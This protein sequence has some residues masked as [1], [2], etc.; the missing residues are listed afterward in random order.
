MKKTKSLFI[1][2]IFCLLFF[3]CTTIR[4][5]NVNKEA[6]FSLSQYKTF[7]F[8][9]IDIDTV[10]FPEYKKRFISLEEELTKQFEAHGVK[11]AVSNPE[12]F[13]NIG[14]N[15]QNISETR[16]TDYLGDPQ[17]MYKRDYT[18]DNDDLVLDEFREGSFVIDFVDAK[19]KKLQCMISGD[20]IAVKNEK[21]VK[22][23]QEVGI[24]KIF[25]KI[26]ED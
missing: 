20:A 13:V 7:D 6:E 19:S 2:L 1:L 24:K 25:K 4:V 8:Y 9:Q 17:Y 12:L 22:K 16:K 26:A 11:R 18:W 3:N 23:N 21:D 14:L 10:K 5:Q 15:I